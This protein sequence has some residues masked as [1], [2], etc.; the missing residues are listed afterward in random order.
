[1]F[2]HL[3]KIASFILLLF[4]CFYQSTQI[5]KGQP[6]GE[7]RKA[8]LLLSST[9]KNTGRHRKNRIWDPSRTEDGSHQSSKRILPLLFSQGFYSYPS[10]FWSYRSAF[11]SQNTLMSVFVSCFLS[12]C[13]SC[14]IFK[15]HLCRFYKETFILSDEILMKL[16]L[17]IWLS[18]KDGM[19]SKTLP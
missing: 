2:P 11:S 18:R 13:C 8:L 6:P 5:R 12:F 10:L 14:N 17:P 19:Q 9:K 4:N 1:M 15:L 3:P 16:H 7:Q